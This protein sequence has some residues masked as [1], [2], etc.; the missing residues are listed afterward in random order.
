M[1]FN[2]C[3]N[4]KSYQLR[5]FCLELGI[6]IH[7]TVIHLPI[8]LKR[9]WICRN[10]FHRWEQCADLHQQ[11]EKIYITVCHHHVWCNIR[12]HMRL[13]NM[14]GIMWSGNWLAYVRCVSTILHP[15]LHTPTPI[16]DYQCL[17][18]ITL[19]CS[20]CCGAFHF[21]SFVKIFSTQ[22]PT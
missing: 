6:H 13:G 3:A 18:L 9:Q 20:I 7:W 15:W 8:S 21:R 11:A 5:H 19:I 1:K 12:A 2:P 16:A 17:P 22:N 4:G 14:L 10:H